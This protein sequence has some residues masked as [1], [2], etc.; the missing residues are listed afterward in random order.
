MQA[1]QQEAATMAGM[2]HPHI[3]QFLGLCTLPPCIVTELCARGSLCDVLRTASQQPTLAAALTWRLRLRMALEEARGILYLHSHSPPIVHRDI[4][5]PNL[6]VDEEWHV[7]VSD[8]NLSRIMA[9]Q[10]AGS[11]SS[12]EGVTNPTWLAPEI[13]RGERATTASDVFAFGLVLLEVGRRQP[14]CFAAP[15]CRAVLRF[16][17]DWSTAWPATPVPPSLPPLCAAAAD[18]TAAVGRRAW[19]HHLRDL[20]LGLAS[21]LTQR[22]PKSG[23]VCR[24]F[25]AVGDP[26]LA[27][28]SRKRPRAKSS[29][30]YSTLPNG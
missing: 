29:N 9:D 7:K 1:L 12:T 5:S 11:Q 16:V 17:T 14:L 24:S 4:K 10:A 28:H 6:L 26:V 21:W 13:L 22:G 3:V 25:L 19:L 18:V 27:P 20:S 23:A 30:P 2:R 15:L 8:F